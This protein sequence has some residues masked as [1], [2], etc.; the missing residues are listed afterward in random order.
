[1]YLSLLYLFHHSQKIGSFKVFATP[2]V[3]TKL[4]DFPTPEL[5]MTADEILQQTTLIGYTL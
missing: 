4:G 5:G 3:I 1:L 2:A